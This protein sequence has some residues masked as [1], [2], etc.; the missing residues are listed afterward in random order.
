M[1]SEKTIIGQCPLCGGNVVKTLKGYACE[2]NLGDQPSCS[3]FLFATV[4]NRRFSDAEATQFL[5][6]KKILLDGF[7]S[8]EGKNFTSLLQFNPDGTVKM[9]AEIGTCPKC[10]GIL[11]VGSR[12][13]S[14]GNFRQKENPCNFT[15]WRNNGGHE[16]TLKEIEL[17]ITLGAT[18]E[19]V[20]TYD[21]QGICRKHRFGLNDSKEVIRI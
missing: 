11:Y 12:S 2:N 14:C 7:A 19:P 1:D 17:L 4:G 3:F 15:I 5:F 18:A 20:E 9:T 6:D 13:V 16:F 21:S 10:H 8:R